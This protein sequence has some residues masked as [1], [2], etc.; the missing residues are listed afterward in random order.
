M[1][2]IQR[3][4]EDSS[5]FLEWGKVKLVIDPWLEGS[6]IDGF[7]WLNEQWHSTDP[8]SINEL[9]AYQAILVS[10]SYEDHCHTPT[11]AKMDSNKPILAAPKA[12]DKLK[13]KFP[14]RELMKLSSE[15]PVGLGELSFISLTPNK[16]L[17]PIYY[18]IL[19]TNTNNE[20]IFYCP[21]GFALSS[22]QLK[23]FEGIN[24]K[25]LITTFTEFDLPSILG[26]KVNP[27]LNNV[28]QIKGQINPE[29]IINTHD[30]EKIMKGLVAKTAKITYANYQE[31]EQS[32]ELNFKYIKGY[33]P[34]TI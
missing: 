16:R 22:Q 3:L 18:G 30:E 32:N 6:E 4:T 13:K 17:D 10:Q 7:S 33:E 15:S 28:R 19:I 1:I 14:Q 12:Y 2:K 24:I 5:W 26:G 31:L 11:L 21:H 29:S 34:V 8:V 9:P 27:G 20:G 23:A 25:L